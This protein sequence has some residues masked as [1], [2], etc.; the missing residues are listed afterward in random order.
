MNEVEI[1][2]LLDQAQTAFG[3]QQ[4][5]NRWFL[6]YANSVEMAIGGVGKLVIE[7]DRLVGIFPAGY[8]AEHDILI[9]SCLQRPEPVLLETAV[10][11][12]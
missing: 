1:Q 7:T 2:Q 12:C 10:S 9:I 3:L 5:P 6:T 8:N 4:R 11:P